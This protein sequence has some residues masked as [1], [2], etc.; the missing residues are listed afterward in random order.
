M[1]KKFKQFES[2]IEGGGENLDKKVDN[3]LSQNLHKSLNVLLSYIEGDRIRQDFDFDLEKYNMLPE[4]HELFDNEQYEELIKTVIEKSNGDMV[5][6]PFMHIVNIKRY[7]KKV[8][9]TKAIKKI[10]NI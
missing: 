2:A 5:D 6:H 4:V 10:N 3:F 1:I 9:S 7:L 8:N